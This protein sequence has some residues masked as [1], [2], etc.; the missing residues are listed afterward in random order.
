MSCLWST[1]KQ[2][3]QQQQQ[4]KQQQQHVTFTRVFLWAQEDIIVILCKEARDKTRQILKRHF[5]NPSLTFKSYL[6][7]SNTHCK[8][9]IKNVY[10]KTGR[11]GR[12]VLG[13]EQCSHKLYP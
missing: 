5:I 8:I 12:V 7:E 10:Q 6:K 4:Q 3:Q 1:F 11:S 9:I 2:K 13:T